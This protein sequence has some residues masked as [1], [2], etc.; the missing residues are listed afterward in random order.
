MTPKLRTTLMGYSIIHGIIDLSCA[1][2]VLASLLSYGVNANE[3]FILIV[4]YNI[5]AFG[6]QA[7]FGLLIDKLKVP[8][9][10]AI[11][12]SLLV[13]SSFFVFNMPGLV[14]ILSGLGNAFFHVG[15]GSISLNFSLRKAFAPGIFVAPGALG[16]TIGVLIGKS[17]MFIAWPFVLL[18]IASVLFII[19]SEIP[20][21]NYEVVS[22]KPKVKYFELVLLLLLFSVS[23]RA[24]YGLNAAWKSDITLLFLLTLGIVLG[25]ALGGILGDR[26]GFAK[27]AIG[28]LVISAPL[29]AFFPNSPLLVILGAFLFQMTMPIALTTL[30]NIL[31]GRSAFAFGLS[32]LA[33]IIGVIPTYMG[34]KAFLSNQY[35]IL[36]IILLCALSLLISF[37]LL[38]NY[39][40]EI[41]IRL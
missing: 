26:F 15:G 34:F 32:V 16:L 39:F 27:T 35:V 7:P 4:L 13:M 41:R 25:K 1:S 31:P 2:V 33:L 19:K 21:I 30:S 29:L 10:S 17:G 24:L 3:S 8:K 28:S 36:S 22:V 6:L 40:K 18:L 12:G 11:V 23:I 9:E 14:V 38:Y 20:E 5:L 37:R